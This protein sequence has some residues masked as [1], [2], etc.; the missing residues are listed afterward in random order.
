MENSLNFSDEIKETAG[1]I[2][3]AGAWGLNEFIVFMAIFGF[4]VFVVIFLLLS[5]YTSKNTDLMIDVVNKNSEA[6]NK[7]SSATEK[8]S[9]ILAANFATNKEKLNEIHD[10][11]KEIKQNV[12]RRRPPKNNRFSEH[13][14]D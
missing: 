13:I 12:R 14:N 5:R 6:I 7:Q 8:L 4:I 10:D 2:N 3:L 1:L 11:V 9:D